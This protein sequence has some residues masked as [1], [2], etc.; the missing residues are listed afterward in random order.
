[1]S[2]SVTR[3]AALAATGSIAAAALI[4]SARASAAPVEIRPS[5]RAK[6]DRIRN[7]AASH[8]RYEAEVYEPARARA[9][10]AMARLRHA[11]VPMGCVNSRGEAIVFSTDS[12]TNVAIATALVKEPIS[13]ANYMQGC[14]KL[15]IAHMRRKAREQQVRLR[16]GLDAAIEKSN[17]FGDVTS[18]A[19]W[20]F[21]RT[22]VST[23]AELHLK[24]E[25]MVERGVFD[26]DD[27]PGEILK[28][29][30]ALAGGAA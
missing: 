11:K 29:V 6:L 8:E 1:M 10:A 21:V 13:D 15:V 28:D 12:P 9:A 14:H 23:I 7:L 22:R 5:F 3:R 18:A 25:L 20:A 24:M 17:R 27:A 4:A 30:V 26:C 16:T 19:E 2:T